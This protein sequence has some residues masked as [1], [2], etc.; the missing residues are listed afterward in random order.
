MML[1]KRAFLLIIYVILININAISQVSGDTS[2]VIERENIRT[3]RLYNL[4]NIEGNLVDSLINPKAFL[5]ENDDIVLIAVK[6]DSSFLT[7]SI[8]NW[9]YMSLYFDHFERIN[10]DSI[11][12]EEI[13]LFFKFSAGINSNSGGHSE[14]YGSF[15][16]IDIDS[17]EL[18]LRED[19]YNY[20]ASWYEKGDSTIS[21]VDCECYDVEFSYK[22]VLLKPIDEE[23]YD[24]KEPKIEYILKD[25]KIYKNILKQ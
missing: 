16:L 1:A 8:S 11:G 7:F 13:V 23:D 17:A 9:D 12:S 25:N 18:I 24:T 5:F 4:S 20:Y 14:R 15:Y 22:K 19:H 3:E 2:I 21:S 6:E 10:F